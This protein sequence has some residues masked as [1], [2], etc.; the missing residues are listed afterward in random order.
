MKIV[1]LK[2]DYTGRN[3]ER[4]R[5]AAKEKCDIVIEFHFNAAANPN[6]SGTEVW[7]R[8]YSLP[9]RSL[10]KLLH[11]HVV[12][13]GFRPRGIKSTI[14]SRRVSF[15][16]AYPR[17]SVVVLIEPC[18][19]TNLSD[20][21]KLH[22]DGFMAQLADAIVNAIN[23]FVAKEKRNV[24]VIGLSV[25]HIGKTSNKFDR[26]ARCLF[27]DFEADHASV[28]AK[29]VAERFQSQSQT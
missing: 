25:G 3:K 7:Y 27:G 29:L 20:A 10:A 23:E 12:S 1:W 16:D 4:Q 6:A 21:Q 2:G 28:L 15:I 9:S 17:T 24:R 11:D 19:V 8:K 18:F 5:Q 14:S 22:Q 13:L 26:G